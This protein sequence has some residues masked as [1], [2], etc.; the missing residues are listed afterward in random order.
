MKVI[1]PFECW[2]QRQKRDMEVTI[3]ITALVL[4]LVRSGSNILTS[5]LGSVA[6][7]CSDTMKE[8]ERKARVR[9]VETFS[10]L[11][12][13][14]SPSLS[15]SLSDRSHPLP[16][17]Q[18]HIL[19][20]SDPTTVKTHYSLS[21]SI[22]FS[23]LRGEKLLRAFLFLLSSP[24]SSVFHLLPRQRIILKYNI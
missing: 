24:R 10:L 22:V 23:E 7:G 4:L 18:N 2:F 15:R 3:R 14:A 6:V 13:P 11:L 17:K 8:W 21:L 20:G 19:P 1:D 16:S 9:L 5:Q 12:F